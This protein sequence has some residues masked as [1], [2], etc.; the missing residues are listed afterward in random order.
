MKLYHIK[1]KQANPNKLDVKREYLILGSATNPPTKIGMQQLIDYFSLQNNL[2]F[3]IH[4]AGY[5]T[6][7]LKYKKNL[8]IQN[9]GTISKEDLLYLLINVDGIIINQPTTSGALTRIVEN[10]IAGI[11]IYANF[12]AAR[13]FYN[14]SDIYIYETFEEL[15]NLLLER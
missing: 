8:Q 15:Q 9:H 2:S 14:L 10:R 6:E 13:D 11:P 5:N 1:R 12:G 7:I 4:V 3:V